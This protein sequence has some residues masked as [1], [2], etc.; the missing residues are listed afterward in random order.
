[1]TFRM[2]RL[3]FT[4]IRYMVMVLI[5]VGVLLSDMSSWVLYPLAVILGVSVVADV[6]LY[7]WNRDRGR[8]NRL[9]GDEDCA[10]RGVQGQAA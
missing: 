7:T 5:P 8:V 2:T 10:G 9:S 4:V 6:V 3:R 1:V